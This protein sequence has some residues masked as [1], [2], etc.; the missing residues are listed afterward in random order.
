MGNASKTWLLGLDRQIW[1]LAAGRLLSQIGTG[2]T[3][4]YAPIFF[5]NQVGLSA[6]QVGLALGSASV[7]GVVGRFLGGTGADNPAWGRKKT[8]LA[9]AGVS[10]IADVALATADTFW[11]LVLGNLLMGLG[12]GLYWPATET[13]V[14]DLTSG[15][16]RNEAFALVRLA[17]N[18]GLGTGVMLGGLIIATI[19]NYRLLFVLD[20]ISFV[21]FFGV[22]WVAIAETYQS[23]EDVQA[24]G[25]SWLTALQDQ[26]LV[27]YMAVNVMF[28]LYIA[29]IQSTAPLYL[30]NFIEFSPQVISGLFAWHIVFASVCQLPIARR[31]NGLSRPHALMVSLLLWGMGFT[32]MWGAGIGAIPALVGAIAS[33]GILALATDAYTPAASALVVDLAP[34]SQRGVYLALN[35]QCWAIGYLIGPPIGGWALDQVPAIAHGFWLAG[36]VSIVPCLL[37]LR[38]L[39]TLITHKK[40]EG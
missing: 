14:A 18:I 10:A 13:V 4:F 38:Y 9:A 33:L 24:D 22:I 36:A 32:V 25:N 21:V 20:G 1:I 7:S 34:A 2:F 26:R 35:S 27:I 40:T 39:E 8:L 19:Q 29:Q 31:L 16:Q 12:I 30:T 23:H 6:T 3:A 11:L 15:S 37:T 17:D 5:V 28:T